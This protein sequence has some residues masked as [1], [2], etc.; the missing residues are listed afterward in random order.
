[1]YSQR[2]Y[3]RLCIFP[4]ILYKARLTLS[5]PASTVQV[6]FSAPRT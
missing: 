4:V 5:P 2:L 1:M 3:E 6:P